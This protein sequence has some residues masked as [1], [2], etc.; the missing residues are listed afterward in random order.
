MTSPLDN[1]PKS[2]GLRR[3]GEKTLPDIARRD[4]NVRKRLLVSSVRFFLDGDVEVG[5][6]ALRDY[7]DA[8][9]G[10]KGLSELTGLP[11]E[12]LK[13][14]FSR[15][16]NPEVQDLFEVI[17]KMYRREGIKLEVE[18][19]PRFTSKWRRKREYARHKLR[20]EKSHRLRNYPA[21]AGDERP[22]ARAAG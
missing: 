1:V 15:N 19:V 12:S 18:A 2:L 3:Y 16:S 17:R 22:G 13:A 14:M 9:I 11:S 8:R 20:T 6:A 4:P 5:K 21:S 7:I 10:Y